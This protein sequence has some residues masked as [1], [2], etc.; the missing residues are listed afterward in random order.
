MIKLKAY[1]SY[2]KQWVYIILGHENE[3]E[4][5]YKQE[6]SSSEGCC[7]KD[8]ILFKATE[9]DADN[10]SPKRWSDLEQIEIING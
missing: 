1:D 3:D 6:W 5:H 9:G 10:C 2:S 7:Y 4:L 8:N